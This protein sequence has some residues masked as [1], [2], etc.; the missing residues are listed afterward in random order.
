VRRVRGH[1]SGHQPNKMYNS[2]FRKI[3]YLILPSK[4]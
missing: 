1:K 4:E 2:F 3:S